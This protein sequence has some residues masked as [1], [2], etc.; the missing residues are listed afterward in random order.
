[1][2]PFLMDYELYS[3]KILSWNLHC[4]PPFVYQNKNRKEIVNHVCQVIT[5]ED[6][7]LICLQDVGRYDYNQIH[8][9]F[10][11]SYGF[12][13]VRNS[14]GE[15]EDPDSCTTVIMFKKELVSH[16]EGKHYMFHSLRLTE[17]L[18]LFQVKVKGNVIVVM[19]AQLE[20][21][22]SNSKERQQQLEQIFQM[23]SKC[24]LSTTAIFAGSLHITD[25]ELK[26][27]MRQFDKNVTELWKHLHLKSSINDQL[28]VK[29]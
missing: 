7:L 6:P 28:S 23:M 3:S 4:R 26:N 5:R 25:F 15:I 8:N 27:A 14:I 22:K 11:Q 21:R 10:R 17:Y 24:P 19:T 20:K 18:H 13:S 2:Q 29:N 12:H 9:A 16:T 1:M